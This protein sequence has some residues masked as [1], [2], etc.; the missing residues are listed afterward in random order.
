MQQND[1][2]INFVQ[3]EKGENQKSL[4]KQRYHFNIYFL[5]S[6]TIISIIAL[7]ILG[8][9]SSHLNSKVESLN[10]EKEELAFLMNNQHHVYT[11][12][13]EVNIL[14]E[15]L[16]PHKTDIIKSLHELNLLREWTGKGGLL[17]IYKSSID[18]AS[19]SVF[20]NKTK[21]YRKLLL[22]MKTQDKKTGEEHRFGA[23]TK[24]NFEHNKFPNKLQISFVPQNHGFIY[25]LDEEKMYSVSDV[26]ESLP[27]EASDFLKGNNKLLLDEPTKIC[28]NKSDSCSI[29]EVEV[30]KVYYYDE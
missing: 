29:K 1:F 10:K 21:N 16:F 22:V 30:Y 3:F 15:I 7:I 6:F 9:Y 18:G 20:H 26:M 25:S 8:Y 13:P 14:N 2:K 5:V 23:F 4:K 24:Y 19:S 11:E 12:V 17:Q 27:L 28:S